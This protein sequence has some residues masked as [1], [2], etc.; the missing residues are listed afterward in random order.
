MVLVFSHTNRKVTETEVGSR[1]WVTAVRN[2]T[3]LLGF[4][5]LFCFEIQKMFGGPRTRKAVECRT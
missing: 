4:V 5:C 2:L 3:M 1:E